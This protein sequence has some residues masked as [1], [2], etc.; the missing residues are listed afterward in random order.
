MFGPSINQISFRLGTLGD[1]RDMHRRLKAA[2][3]ADDGMLVGN[4]GIAWSIYFPDPEGNNIEV[5]VDTPWYMLQPFLVPLDL[6]KSDA[7]IV[8]ATEAMCRENEGFEPIEQ[9][10]ARIGRKMT[11]FRAPAA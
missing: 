3:Y 7:E 4:H 2:G 10:R 5:F 11:P 1:L 8:A 6:S 9:W